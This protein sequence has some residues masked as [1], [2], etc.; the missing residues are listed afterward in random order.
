MKRDNGFQEKREK[1]RQD[2][3]DINFPSGFEAE[4]Q[5]SGIFNYSPQMKSRECITGQ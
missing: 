4:G 2:G 3:K 1:A 5:P